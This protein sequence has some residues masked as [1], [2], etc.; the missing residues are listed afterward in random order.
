MTPFIIPIFLPQMGCPHRC[1]YCQQEK[2]TRWPRKI[3]EQE[4]FTDLIETGLS[5]K[6]KKDGMKVEIAFF[7]GTF[8]N[9]PI[10]FQEKVFSWTAPYLEKRKINAIRLST[11]PEALTEEKINWLWLQGVRSL[12]IGVQSLNDNV[13]ELSQRGH[14]AQEC[15]ETIKL[16]KKYPLGIGVQL[17]MGLPGDS[18]ESFLETVKQI[19]SLG[20]HFVRV[21]PTLILKDTPLAQMFAKGE[22]I[23]LSL[24]ESVSLAS[25]VLELFEESGIK[26][27]RLGLQDHEGL[28]P[29]MDLIAGPFH[30]AFGSLVRGELFLRILI[31]KLKTDKTLGTSL[32][33]R[34][35]PREGDYLLGH[36]KKNLLLLRDE[37]NQTNIQIKIDR[38]LPPGHWHN[39]IHSQVV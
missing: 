16:L 20:P 31:R 39:E 14:T 19:I 3:L 21:Y 15:I 6:R 11:R 35:A 1:I 27:I 9:L 36:N 28:R 26:V 18:P 30:P 22:Y 4:T 32:I 23:P 17:M 5:S 29:G 10:D 8:T 38:Q 24:D 2:I 7:G 25:Q 33:L 12:E 13:L 34:L 37:L